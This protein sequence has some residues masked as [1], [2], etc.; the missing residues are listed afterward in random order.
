M[1]TT[2][3]QTLRI[4]DLKSNDAQPPKRHENAR[5]LNQSCLNQSCLNQSIETYGETFLSIVGVALCGVAY[6][7]KSVWKADKEEEQG[8]KWK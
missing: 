3:T 6:A 7:V 4:S 2:K 8:G 5:D 1:Q